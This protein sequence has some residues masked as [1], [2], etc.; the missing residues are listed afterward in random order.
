VSE[1]LNN[2]AARLRYWLTTADKAAKDKSSVAGWSEV[3]GLDQS[4]M[5]HRL[6]VA[7]R[8]A[9]LMELAQQVRDNMATLPESLHPDLLLADFEEVERT[10]E[11]FTVAPSLNMQQFLDPL[12]PTG[13]RS[14]QLA[15]TFLGSHQP[16][17]WIDDTTQESLLTQIR[18]VIDYVLDTSELDSDTRAFV[19]ARLR[20]V[21]QA[22]VEFRLRGPAS[23]EESADSLLGGMI[24]KSDLGPKFFTS[25]TGRRVGGVIAAIA[26]ALGMA[27]DYKTSIAPSHD[28]PI[29]I[30]EVG[31]EQTARAGDDGANSSTG[32]PSH[33]DNDGPDAHSGASQP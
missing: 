8:G 24:R 25:P 20:N 32:T 7:K 17:A 19:I 12:K 31:V 26:M 5:V 28:A 4:L 23:L 30:L 18:G 11:N 10:L 33:S 13:Q 3:F 16:E 1:P 15:S 21:E 2:P 9:L 6:E 14:L 22:V 29:I 27:A